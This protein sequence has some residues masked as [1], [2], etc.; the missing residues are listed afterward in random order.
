[1][2]NYQAEAQIALRCLNWLVGGLQKK[3]NMIC[4]QYHN[5]SSVAGDG[6]MAGA[7]SLPAGGPAPHRGLPGHRYHQRHHA[8]VQTRRPLPRRG[9]RRGLQLEPGQMEN[10]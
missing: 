2:C 7:A 6:W 1:M 9:A 5:H 10:I 4:W 3:S 8:G